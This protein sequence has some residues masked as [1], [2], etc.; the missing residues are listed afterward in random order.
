MDRRDLLAVIG[1]TIAMPMLLTLLTWSGPGVEK[2][3]L[4]AVVLAVTI[5]GVRQLAR[6]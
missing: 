2:Y 1:L 6:D 5:L 3:P 4:L